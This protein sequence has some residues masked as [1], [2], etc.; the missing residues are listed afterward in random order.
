MNE[1]RGELVPGTML[2]AYRVE[3]RLGGGGVGTVYAAEEPT[4]R[5]RV[6]IKVL[7]HSFAD[8]AAAAARFE[9][10]ARAANDVRHPGIVDVFAI[11]K[12]PDGRPY[13]VMSLLEGRSLRE[14]IAA[15][16]RF[17]PG[18]A[19]ALA[20][21]IG[22][23]LAAAHDAGIIHRD[24]KPD[25]VFIER[26][27]GAGNAA[28]RP[29]PRILD[30]GLAKVEAGE[31]EPS[32]MKLT[33][34]GVPMGTPAYMAPEQ[35]W[36]D[37]VEARTD[38]YA[39]GVMLFEMLAGRPPFGA[40]QFIELAQ[41]HLHEPPPSLADL[42]VAAA[43]AVE[44]LLT[45]ALAK[46][47]QERFESMRALLA[48]GEQAF[49]SG[50]GVDGGPRTAMG[51]EA[52]VLAPE[53]SAGKVSPLLGVAA[54]ARQRRQGDDAP[55]DRTQLPS[56]DAL[57]EPS[58]TA[59]PLTRPWG[60]YAAAHIATL[61]VGVAT[62]VAVGY[63]GEDR[64]DPR[65]WSMIAGWASI[66]SLVL[67][68]V[69][70][71]ALLLIARRRARD[72]RRTLL[73]WWLALL[74]GI[75][76]AFG[77]YT[78]WVKVT[79][80]T[81]QAE[82]AAQMPMF[83][84][85]MYEANAARFIGLWM[86]TLLLCSLAAL[87]GLSGALSTGTT[88]TGALGVRR[89]ESLAAVAVLLALTTVAVWVAAPSGALVAGT[90]AWVLLLGVALP[91][92]HPVTAARDEIER[93]L[94]GL[95]A[96]LVA[97]AVG[98]ARVEAREAALWNEQP[99]RAAR[100][101][102][103]LSASGERTA[104]VALTVASLLVLAAVEAIRLR[105]LWSRAEL[106][107]STHGWVLG[108]VVL[109]VAI[110][111]QALHTRFIGGR[112][113][114]RRA[115]EP[116]FTL[117]ARLD[118][119]EGAALDRQRFAPHVAPAL[120]IAR[121]R[122]AINGEGVARLSALESPEVAMAV[123]GALAKALTTAPPDTQSADEAPPPDLAVL[124]DRQVSWAQAARILGLARGAGAR[125]IELLLTRGPGP[126]L[127]PSAPPEAG[128]A[129]VTDFVAIPAELVDEPSRVPPEQRYGQLVPELLA[130]AA[131]GEPVRLAVGR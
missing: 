33:Q 45:R 113:D 119:P 90:A 106:R 92:V 32:P 104:T 28:R 25:N 116:Q 60:R 79:E 107:P 96:V 84:M 53:G 43:P 129:I 120:Q 82:M 101:A 54:L 52:T 74:P 41:Q 48:A 47:P 102:E 127:S 97:A 87:P 29:R 56:S 19:W 67:F 11:G 77:T 10:E 95:L 18:E 83:N 62:I 40:Q 31:G 49:G 36:A 59:P 98:I 72:G 61:V 44:A 105:R 69:A 2:G 63:A 16:G 85:G 66:G 126:E 21:E 37:G 5:K 9:R 68:V 35:W 81:R 99:T 117:F 4:I 65:A 108:L 91:A 6:A 20:H 115:L 55:L 131:A 34:S 130:A 114:L 112:D 86:S 7:R 13:L 12:L 100:A 39:F 78:G 30:F 17:E 73:P 70:L 64:H 88:L 51:H 58:P 57:D 125:R 22:E 94:A 15:R 89:R 122:V 1:E 14:E 128:F 80:G 93:A 118:P 3:Y 46:K 109:G 76:G 50:A 71:V 38:Q 103:I 27:A 75:E 8:D 121:D 124:V 123:T 26:Y 111:D 24:L 110:G 23:A 42:G